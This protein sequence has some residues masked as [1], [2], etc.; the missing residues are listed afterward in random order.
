MGVKRDFLCFFLFPL[1]ISLL[2]RLPIFPIHPNNFLVI[3]RT[4][5]TQTCISEMKF[6]SFEI[7]AEQEHFLTYQFSIVNPALSSTGLD[8]LVYSSWT[9]IW[10]AFPSLCPLRSCPTS[11]VQIHLQVFHA[12]RGH[13]LGPFIGLVLQTYLS[14]SEFASGFFQYTDL[15]KHFNS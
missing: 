7:S 6:G 2:F 1:L 11:H 12:A 15:K 5:H 4:Q 10:A 8:H 9:C 13:W 14:E 3:G